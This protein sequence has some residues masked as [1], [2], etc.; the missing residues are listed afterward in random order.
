MILGYSL[1]FVLTWIFAAN[2]VLNRA[3]K[4]I[5]SGVI[6][7]WHGI[8]GIL[9]ALIAVGVSYFIDSEPGSGLS[10]LNYSAEVYGLIIAATLC[11]TLAVNS[12]TIAFQS[13]SSGFVSLISYIGVIYAFTADSLIFNE[14][15]SW[16]ELV[17][18]VCILIVTVTTS[19]IKL[20]E[21]NRIKQN[22]SEDEFTKVDDD[23]AINCSK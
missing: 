19:I 3:L 5:N 1:I 12:M 22:Q 15:F 6:M 18:A 16:V 23:Q 14:H 10:I 20:R 17:A 13:D 21:G 7:F 4:G 9:F 8:I 11:D 2:C